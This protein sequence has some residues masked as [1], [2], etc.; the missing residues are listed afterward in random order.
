MRSTRRSLSYLFFKLNPSQPHLSEDCLCIF[1]L[2]MACCLHVF[3]L[4]NEMQ[5]LL[6]GRK[7]ERANYIEIYMHVNQGC[8]GGL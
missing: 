7:L 3:A 5:M 1:F 4:Y 8:M 6:F 2:L